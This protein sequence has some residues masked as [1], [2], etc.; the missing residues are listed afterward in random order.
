MPETTTNLYD[1]D[2]KFVSRIGMLDAYELLEQE[3]AERKWRRRH[4]RAWT[5]VG[6]RMLPP[7]PPPSDSATS[8]TSIDDKDMITHGAAIADDRSGERTLEPFER[9][10]I[11]KVQ[12]WPQVIRGLETRTTTIVAGRGATHVRTLPA[13]PSRRFS[14]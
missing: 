1:E 7:P 10:L 11:A 12:A 6:I 4:G 14:L 5:F 3:R 2:D 13:D 8:P 9:R